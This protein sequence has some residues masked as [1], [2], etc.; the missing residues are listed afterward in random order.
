MIIQERCSSSSDDK[1][2]PATKH[3]RAA[4]YVY[5]TFYFVWS[6]AGMVVPMVLVSFAFLCARRAPIPMRA[7]H[8]Y[9][10]CYN[11]YNYVIIMRTVGSG[12]RR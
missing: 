9:Y 2:A 4:H 12:W 11:C 1:S 6:H 8:Y 7:M 3:S 5:T 10:N